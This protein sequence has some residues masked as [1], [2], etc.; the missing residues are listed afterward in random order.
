MQR[1]K[2]M[3][4]WSIGVLEHCKNILLLLIFSLIAPSLRYSITPM[5][6]FVEEKFA[7]ARCEIE[8]KEFCYAGCRFQ[9][10]LQNVG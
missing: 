1:S 6:G 9:N 3:E 2:G 10:L 4:C 8:T 7:F 5:K